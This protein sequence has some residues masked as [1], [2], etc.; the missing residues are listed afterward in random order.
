MIPYVYNILP[1]LYDN[2]AA[3]PLARSEVLTGDEH[4]SSGPGG[5]KNWRYQEKRFLDQ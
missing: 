2:P 4:L 1:A 5:A 3:A